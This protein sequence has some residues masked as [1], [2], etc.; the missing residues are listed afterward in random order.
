MN[1][2]QFYVKHQVH[3]DG[4]DITAKGILKTIK[5]KLYIYIPFKVSHYIFDNNNIRKECGVFVIKEIANPL[6]I[7]SELTLLKK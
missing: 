1:R 3:P 7:V 4:G 2:K 6:S 5:S